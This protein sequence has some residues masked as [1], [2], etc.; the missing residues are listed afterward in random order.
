MILHS[1]F[2][3]EFASR[4]LRPIIFEENAS[5]VPKLNTPSPNSGN[6]GMVEVEVGERGVAGLVRHVYGTKNTEADELERRIVRCLGN[7]VFEEES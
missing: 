3:N 5:N 6:F 2:A 7:A 1:S 4:S